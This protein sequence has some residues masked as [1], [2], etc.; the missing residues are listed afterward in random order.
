V[1]AYEVVRVPGGWGLIANRGWGQY[2]RLYTS[3][4]KLWLACRYLDLNG[5]RRAR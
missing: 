5:Y 4:L 3:R 1:N 2:V